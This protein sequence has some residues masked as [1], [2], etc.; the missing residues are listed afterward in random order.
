MSSLAPLTCRPAAPAPLCLARLLTA[1]LALLPVW[2][3]LSWGR[4]EAQETNPP[5]PPAP[6]PTAT[7][8]LYEVTGHGATAYLFGTVHLPDRRVV[9][10]PR[11]VEQAFDASDA[12]YTEIE[13]TMKAELEV[14][15]ASMLSDGRKLGDVLGAELAARFE[16]R[17]EK[18]GYGSQR[19]MFERFRP[20]AAASMLPL[21]PILADMARQPPLDKM[22]F[23]R[24]QEARKT[25]GGLETVAEQ[26]GVFEG[27]S[28]AEQVTMVKETLDQLDRYEAAGRDALEEMILAW[29][30][31]DPAKLLDL[32]EEGFGADAALSQKLEARLVWERN[33]RLA[34]RIHAKITAKPAH[35]AFFALGALHLPDGRTKPDATDEERARVRGVIT[36]LRAHGYTVTARAAAPEPVP[37]GGK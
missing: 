28:E 6:Q 7:P 9:T 23:E 36:L 13:T 10:L 3:G 27:L 17:V 24:A 18:A 4:A 14:A 15:T 29:L 19:G 31:G 5:P 21:L 20:W 33:R 22:L 34:D 2:L 35:T 8:F 16:A 12:V 37:F 32:L 25:V 30:S 1:V 11:A 26:I